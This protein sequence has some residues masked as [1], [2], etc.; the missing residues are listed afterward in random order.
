M[1]RPFS[2]KD[3]IHRDSALSVV[4]EKDGNNYYFAVKQ[5]RPATVTIYNVSTAGA[6][7]TAVATGLTGVLSWKL[8][9]KNGNPNGFDYCFDGVGA[10]Y[11][12]CFG[13]L[14][15]DTEITTIYVRRKTATDLDMQLEVW[16]A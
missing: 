16:G 14:Q 1:Q 15:R 7:W 9:E 13:E 11:M 4:L 10:T 8:V 3:S 12:T 2:I 6:G 5:I